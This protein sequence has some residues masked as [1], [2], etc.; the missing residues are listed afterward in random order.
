MT[1]TYSSKD[2]IMIKR[3]QEPLS[4]VCTFAVIVIAAFFVGWLPDAVAQTTFTDADVADSAITTE[5][6]WD[7]GLPDNVGNVG[8]VSGTFAATYA[9]DQD[10]DGKD[11]IFEG[12]SSLTGSGVKI[13]DSTLTFRG[14]SVF[15]STGTIGVAR[16]LLATNTLNIQ[17][18][19]SVI[20]GNDLK[21]GRAGMAILNQ[22]GGSLTIASA[23]EIGNTNVG[24]TGALNLSGGVITAG[25]LELQ[26]GVVDF[27][28]N[29]TGSISVLNGGVDFT[30]DFESFINSGGITI[31]G[32]MAATSDFLITYDGTTKTTLTVAAAMPEAL[33]LIVNSTTGEVTMTNPSASPI[34]IDYYE[35]RSAEG[36]LIVGNVP[37]DYN[38]DN[39]TNAADYT[40]WRD[41]LGGS[42]PSGDG[43]G[44]DLLGEPDGDVDQFD[45]DYWK[46]KLG[47]EGNGWVSLQD[48][49][50]EGNGLPGDGNGWEEGLE[51]SSSFVYET[52]LTGSS[53]I[54][55]GMDI[56][57]G[58]LFSP[59]GAQTLSFE[60]HVAGD[61]PEVFIT[62]D[63]AYVGS[64]ALTTSVPEPTSLLLLALAGGVFMMRRSMRQRLW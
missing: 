39:V 35:V 28:T 54:T 13:D 42:G 15:E 30:P 60:Y 49:D 8:T 24:G 56:S 22:S 11:M 59:V 19:A 29:S 41:N 27:T 57:L 38:S 4:L 58:K 50:Y 1:I 16:D 46:D 7:N 33:G 26:I 53:D 20:A 34:A 44:D 23:L 55:N 25:S 43:T 61:G 52:Y 9:A 6:N 14:Q 47:A 37:A 18:S 63:V 51:L 32:A 36:E 2:P 10:L 12:M 64:A 45:Y 62:G 31:G 48:Q 3:H 5:E 21:L 17:E 40:V